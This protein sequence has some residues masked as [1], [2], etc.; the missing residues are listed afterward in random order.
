MSEKLNTYIKNENTVPVRTKLRT[1]VAQI[2]V[3][4]PIAEVSIQINMLYIDE[5]SKLISQ[6]LDI[7]SLIYP[8]FT[9]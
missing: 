4:G 9:T 5:I 1:R 2:L 7:N 6:S 8:A 3:C